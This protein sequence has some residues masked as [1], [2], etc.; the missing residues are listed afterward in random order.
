[1]GAALEGI[2]SRV[3][4][5]QGRVDLTLLLP[6]VSARQR[7]QALSLNLPGS[8]APVGA[9]QLNK[10]ALLQP[11][12]DR[13]H[14]VRNEKGWRNARSIFNREVADHHF[15]TRRGRR[16]DALVLGEYRIADT[17]S[18]DPSNLVR[19]ES[20]A[21][22]P[23]LRAVSIDIERKPLSIGNTCSVVIPAYELPVDLRVIRGA[24]IDAWIFTHRSP[25]SCRRGQAGYFGGIVIDFARSR[26][27]P[28]TVTLDCV[29]F[30]QV[31]DR[32]KLT[33]RMLAKTLDQTVPELVRDI[34]NEIPATQRWRVFDATDSEIT[35]RDATGSKVTKKK[36][37]RRR[38]VRQRDEKSGRTIIRTQKTVKTVSRQP[39]LG[40][41]VGRSDITVWDAITRVSSLAGV[42]PNYGMS[43]NGK[44]T[45]A[46]LLA[47]QAQTISQA[48]PRRFT[49]GEDLAEFSE[50]L[51]LDVG[52]KVDAIEVVSTDP[53]SGKTYRGRYGRN[54]GGATE[55]NVQFQTV[56]GLGS[57]AECEDRARELWRSQ[58]QGEFSVELTT[59]H[60][61]SRGGGPDDPPELDEGDESLDHTS[62]PVNNSDLLLAE[63][64]EPFEIRFAGLEDASP[65]LGVDPSSRE[66]LGDSTEDAHVRVL[67]AR[68]IPEKAARAIARAHRF[69]PPSLLFQLRTITH[70]VTLEGE[71]SYECSMTLDA[72]LGHAEDEATVF[73]DTPTMGA[74]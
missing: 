69:S 42:V 19:F 35:A 58:W 61:W 63:P 51:S 39:T 33:P 13:Y 15:K 10:P 50:H 38:A 60:P 5:I 65:A 73:E 23:N 22:L 12:T 59:H 54:V 14:R 70:S 2:E 74:P 25:G 57:K 37:E 52:Q 7:R 6:D 18:V 9:V 40:H 41:L 1:M 27:A 36:V 26:A 4:P 47:N 49:W 30:T 67:L 32:H 66:R 29:D 43:R 56:Y 21:Y 55:G 16:K 62:T 20:T 45:I 24:Q 48:F 68:G 8:L 3:L 64:G 31:L 53:D 46:I 72:F 44:P 28:G 34:L 17:L 71:G 11:T